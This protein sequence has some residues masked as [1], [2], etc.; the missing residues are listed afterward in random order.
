MTHMD[1]CYRTKILIEKGVCRQRFSFLCPSRVTKSIKTVS[2]LVNQR[3][4]WCTCH[5]V[6]RLLF[7]SLFKRIITKNESHVLLSEPKNMQHESANQ[8][9]YPFRVKKWTKRK[10]SHTVYDIL[11][12]TPMSFQMSYKR[13]T[14]WQN[15]VP[16][17]RETLDFL[18][19]L[20]LECNILSAL[21][22]GMLSRKRRTLF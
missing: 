16:N 21:S 22:N 10:A 18:V 14:F 13:S 6:I 17:E 2:L 7:H 12:M 20:I 8:E 15:M 1:P 4:M 19:F 5:L 3:T 11:Y 9:T